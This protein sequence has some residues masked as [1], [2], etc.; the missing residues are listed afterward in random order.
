MKWWVH[1]L[2]DLKL[3]VNAVRKLLITKPIRFTWY[4]CSL[5]TGKG[6]YSPKPSYA[7]ISYTITEFVNLFQTI[8]MLH[9]QI[10]I[11][12]HKSSGM[13]RWHTVHVLVKKQP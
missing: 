4:V 3:P 9:D 5:G 7:V 1:T 8:D 2:H 12:Y 13:F 11:L 6:S 10:Q